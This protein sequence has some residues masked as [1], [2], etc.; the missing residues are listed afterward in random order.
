MK[1]YVLLFRM[2]ITDQDVQPTPEQMEQYMKDWMHWINGIAA[3][4]QLAQGGNHL[5]PAGRVLQPEDVT[6]DGP[7][8]RNKES[9]A[10]YIIIWAKDM[11]DA[12]AIA[13]KC[14]IL[15]GKGTSVEIRQTAT[16]NNVKEVE[17]S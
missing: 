3:T 12:T 17:R 8:E 16:P 4:K 1:E 9:V 7:Y 14:P 5:M 11:E 6:K 13:R 15:N 10:G 2:N